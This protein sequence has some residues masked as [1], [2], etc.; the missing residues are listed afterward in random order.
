MADLQEQITQ[1][2]RNFDPEREAEARAVRAIL[3]GAMCMAAQMPRATPPL[4]DL[5]KIY[6]VEQGMTEDGD[7]QDWYTI[8]TEAGHRI[9]VTLSVE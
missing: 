1:L 6:Q 3:Q 5:V 2:A 8:V 7:Y 9:R 4:K